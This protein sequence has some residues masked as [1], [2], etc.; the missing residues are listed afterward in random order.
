L[1]FKYFIPQKGKKGGFIS[2]AESRRQFKEGTVFFSVFWSLVFWAFV[3]FW[4]LFLVSSGWEEKQKPLREQAKI[5]ELQEEMSKGNPETATELGIAL[6]QKGG[7]ENV[8]KGIELLEG[9]AALESLDAT[10]WLAV[11]HW[12]KRSFRVHM[13]QFMYYL[14]Q[15]AFRGDGESQYHLGRILLSEGDKD[16]LLWLALADANRFIFRDRGI[17]PIPKDKL[18][19]NRRPVSYGIK[20]DTWTTSVT[21]LAP[22]LPGADLRDHELGVFGGFLTGQKREEEEYVRYRDKIENLLL[23]NPSVLRDR[24][25][26]SGEAPVQGIPEDQKL[27]DGMTYF[28]LGLYDKAEKNLGLLAKEGIVDSQYVLGWIYFKGLGDIPT[29]R[30]LGYAWWKIAAANADGRTNHNHSYY[31]PRPFFSRNFRQREIK[32]GDILAD[33]LVEEYP[34]IL[35]V[36]KAQIVEG[37]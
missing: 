31:D 30:P 14:K 3:A 1:W 10:K 5:E 7:E 24:F 18:A 2:V 26:L 28:Y 12:N 17:D 11:Y 36:R 22:V 21:D 33:R 20:S 4:M 19:R 29:D 34:S 35:T 6:I 13:D 15:A 32:Q 27:V 8:K 23:E 9:A 16:G 37:N 25:K